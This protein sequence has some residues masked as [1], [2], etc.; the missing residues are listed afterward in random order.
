MENG[1]F[2][3]I[4]AG[5]I[6][7]EE[8]I[9]GF[10]ISVYLARQDPVTGRSLIWGGAAWPDFLG[11]A[12][13]FIAQLGVAAIGDNRVLRI[14]PA[15]AIAEAG[16]W[17][18][19]CLSSEQVQVAIDQLIGLL[20]SEVEGSLYPLSVWLV[21]AADLRAAQLIED[22]RLS[23]F[24][25]ELWNELLEANVMRVAIDDGSATIQGAPQNHGVA[26]KWIHRIVNATPLLRETTEWR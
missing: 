18:R 1:Y 2:L 5:L 24:D 16:V 14:D 9:G 7:E 4:N 22:F 19:W 13:S 21:P 11:W 12:H 10:V 3:S 6:P 15:S 25:E 23:R 8:M 17:P 20:H 26:S